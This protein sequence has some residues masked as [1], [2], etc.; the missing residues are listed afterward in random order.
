MHCSV[1]ILFSESVDSYYIGYTCDTMDN[2][3]IKH[4]AN[5]KGYT[6]KANDWSVKHIEYF[7]SKS[8]AIKRERQIKSWKSRIMIE[9][10]IHSS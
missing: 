5:H 4:N 3:L 2:R 6:G 9:K 10:L 8:E 1:Y 7:N